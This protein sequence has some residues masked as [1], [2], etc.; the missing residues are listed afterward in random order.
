MNTHAFPDIARHI[1]TPADLLDRTRRKPKASL[2]LDM[3]GETDPLEGDFGSINGTWYFEYAAPWG[4]DADIGGVD[5]YAVD[6]CE[7]FCFVLE[8]T[9]VAFTREDVVALIGKEAVER[10]EATAAENILQAKKE[11][12]L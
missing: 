8:G 6:Y 4:Y 11:G 9:A 2:L 10:V 5:G 1:E 3:H 12:M 7:L